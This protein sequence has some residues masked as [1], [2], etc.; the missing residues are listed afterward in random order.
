VKLFS[1][2][3]GGIEG[4]LRMVD[5]SSERAAIIALAAITSKTVCT[6]VGVRLMTLSTLLVAAW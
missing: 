3:D 4:Y 6:S 5:E 2:I 1:P